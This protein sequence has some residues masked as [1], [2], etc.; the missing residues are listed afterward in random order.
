[1]KPFGTVCFIGLTLL[2]SCESGSIS[3]CQTTAVSLYERAQFECGTAVDLT[4]L[5]SDENYSRVVDRQ[6]NSISAENIMKADALHP[7]E[8]VY[9]FDQADQLATY[10]VENGKRLHG[11]TLVWHQQLPD[12]ILNFE[13]SREDW[14]RLLENHISEIVGHFK[15]RVASW[16]VVNEAF[17][18]DGTLRN[19][20]WKR[21]LGP[22][23]IEKAFIYAHRADSNAKLFYNDY[24]LSLN[25][26]KRKAVLNFFN[27]LKAKGVP[28]D[29][30]GMQMHIFNGFPENVKIS[31][32]INDVWQQD[33]RVHIS[34][35][36]ISINPTGEEMHS[37]PQN[38]LERQADKYVYVFQTY[39]RIPEKYKYGITVWGVGDGDS[40]IR[41]YYDRDDYPLLFDENYQPKRAF[42]KLISIL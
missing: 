35:L 33:Y 4:K 19:S 12:W 24:G 5:F 11:H 18:E 1:M 31:E 30:I 26:V 42:C 17:N 37:P 25:P 22:S 15:G 23:Y 13:G 3:P 14:D 6:F 8:N 28:V 38:E 41:D 7:S 34:E 36:D 20:V 16:D 40:W 10:C 39:D 29:G 27:N 9:H 32:A 21:N 2:F